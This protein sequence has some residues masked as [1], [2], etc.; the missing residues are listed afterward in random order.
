MKIEISPHEAAIVR[1][2]LVAFAAMEAEAARKIQHRAFVS[3][4]D[5]QDIQSCHATADEARKLFRQF[6][7]I[8]PL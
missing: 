8:K 1:L 4:Q 7:E 5:T 2:A 3:D 6:C